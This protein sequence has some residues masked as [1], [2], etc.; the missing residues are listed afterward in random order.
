MEISH[1]PS[2]SYKRGL[3]HDQ[4]HSLERY[5]FFFFFLKPQMLI[6][7]NRPQLTL[8]FSLGVERS[9]GLDKYIHPYDIITQYRHRS[10]SSLLCLVMFFH[11]HP[12]NHWSRYCLHSFSFSRT[13]QTWNPTAC[14]F[15]TLA[16][17]TQDYASQPPPR[18]SVT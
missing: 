17:S 6:Y 8:G 14:R 7:H 16:S 12:G 10:K 18:L 9:M 3:A 15:F 2:A 5:F 4:L 11:C 1:I 13:S